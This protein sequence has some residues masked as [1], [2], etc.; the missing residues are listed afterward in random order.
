[1]LYPRIIIT[2][3]VSLCA[4]T[5]TAAQQLNIGTFSSGNTNGWESAGFRGVPESK[6]KIVEL[7]GHKVLRG[8]CDASASL[9]GV[10]KRIDLNATPVMHWSWRVDKVY[11]NLNEKSKA[12]DDYVARVY[13][14]IDGGILQWRTRAINYVWASLV[15]KGTA[16]PNPF[17]DEAMMVVMES[18]ADKVGQWQHESRNVQ[19]DFKRYYDKT[20]GHIDGVAVMTDCDN[21]PSTAQV[22][23]GDIYFTAK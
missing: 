6:Y 14:V 1:M 8:R 20:A 12:G 9:Y 15:P 13:A 16:F 5:A 3:C 21:H 18:G 10:K 4:F 11:A 19:A 7:D 23:F 22:Y 17:H 2:L